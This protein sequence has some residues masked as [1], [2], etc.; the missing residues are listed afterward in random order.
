[1]SERPDDRDA[2]LLDLYRR[3]PGPEPSAGL[4]ATIRAA[5]HRAVA[6]A[7]RRW[8]LPALAT[9]AVVVLAVGVALRLPSPGSVAPV[10]QDLAPAPPSNAG[11]T[12]AP[13]A[14]P[15]R[16]TTGQGSPRA[17]EG[18]A[19]RAT[20]AAPTAPAD[21]RLERMETPSPAAE[22]SIPGTE[23][24][25]SRGRLQAAPA[26]PRAGVAHVVDGAV[27]GTSPQPALAE[28]SA[29]PPPPPDLDRERL[30]QLV[31]ELMAEGRVAEAHCLLEALEPTAAGT[32]SEPATRPPRPTP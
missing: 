8:Y 31:S 22:P 18:P 2:H 29:C 4:D 24:P 12:A 1:M 28:P 5:A 26:A 13:G 16:E 15:A 6:R 19:G 25:P 14:L 9:A 10:E 21:R 20:A 7:T 3:A 30:V 11:D 23:S 32:G 17:M 27:A